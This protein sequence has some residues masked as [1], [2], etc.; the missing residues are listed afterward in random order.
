MKEGGPR[1]RVWEEA[2]LLGHT[3]EKARAGRRGD[4]GG[5]QRQGVTLLWQKREKR[6]PSINTSFLLHESVYAM[7]IS[8]AKI[9]S[10]LHRDTAA[11]WTSLVQRNHSFHVY[12]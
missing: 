12:I 10:R 9:N 2:G 4:M 7:A 6:L 8:W 3:L 11:L 5:L 1:G